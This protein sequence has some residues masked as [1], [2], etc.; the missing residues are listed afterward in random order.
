MAE[1]QYSKKVASQSQDL[2]V[3]S[4]FRSPRLRKHTLLMMVT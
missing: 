4:L 3:L 2:S 1:E